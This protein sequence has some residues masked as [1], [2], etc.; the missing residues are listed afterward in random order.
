MVV[1]TVLVV[2]PIDLGGDL[3]KHVLRSKLSVI[4]V[5]HVPNAKLAPAN[6]CIRWRT[7]RILKLVHPDLLP[8]VS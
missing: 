1:I 5:S 3:A 7:P 8:T 2:I 6:A 4:F